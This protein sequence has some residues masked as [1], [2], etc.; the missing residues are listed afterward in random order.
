[1]R[2]AAPR[3]LDEPDRMLPGW[4]TGQLAATCTGAALAFGAAH[5]PLP[6]EFRAWPVLW[7]P[8]LGAL[9]KRPLPVRGG[10][11]EGLDLARAWWGYLLRPRRTLWK[12]GHR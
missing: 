11:W 10:R 12:G 4:T 2:Y 9:A 7:L 8:V 1:M 6:W 3:N 5:L